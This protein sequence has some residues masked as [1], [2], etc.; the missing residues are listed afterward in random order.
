MTLN[1]SKSKWHANWRYPWGFK[2]WI[3]NVQGCNFKM[4]CRISPSQWLK[5]SLHAVKIEWMIRAVDGMPITRTALAWIISSFLQGL[6]FNWQ[7][8]QP[9]TPI[10]SL[11]GLNSTE[12]HANSQWQWVRK[13][14]CERVE[15]FS[16]TA[17]SCMLESKLEQ[18]LKRL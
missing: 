6:L 8:S 18:D 17:A 3:F 15:S 11:Y 12:N 9:L 5:C 4:C 1:I 13:H 7:H 14:G 2:G 10:P 16:H